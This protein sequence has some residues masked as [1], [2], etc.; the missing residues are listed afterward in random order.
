MFSK[1]PVNRV[2]LLGNL[3]LDAMQNS[4]QWKNERVRGE[5]TTECLTTMF[6]EDPD[7]DISITLWVGRME[8]LQMNEMIMLQRTWSAWQSHS[9]LRPHNLSEQGSSD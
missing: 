5:P 4:R 8:G 1:A 2:H 3:L 9:S 7:Q 6:P